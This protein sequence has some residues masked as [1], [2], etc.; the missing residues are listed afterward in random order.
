M[1][2]SMKVSS[3]L[4][5]VV[6]LSNTLGANVYAEGEDKPLVT[7]EVE[8]DQVIVTFKEDGQSKKT[9]LD[10]VSV[11][12]IET[13]EVATL[14]VP[15]GETVEAFIDE[16]EARTDVESVE[17]DHLVQLTYTPNDPYFSYSQYHH[18]N[19]ETERAWDKT[20]GSS[21]V[22]VAVLDSGFDI[23]HSD[24][25][26]QIVSPLA[27]SDTGFSVDDHGTHV[28]GII[29]SSIDNYAFGAG[30]APETSI[31]PIDVFEDDMAY[32]SD[33]IEGI[34]QAVWAGADII[35]MSMGSYS[36]N[37]QYNN[38]IQYAYQSGLVIVASAGNDS[39]S[40]TRYPASY[41]NVI[42][43]GSTDSSDSQSY[44]SNYGNDVDIVAPGS[45]IYST[46]PYNSGGWMS[47]T[48][49]A[50][51]VVAGVAA[52]LLASEPNLTNDQV[53]DRLLS[54]TKD[55]GEY[56]KDYIYGNGLVNAK[57]ALKIMDIPSPMVPKIYDYSTS[58]IGYLSFDLENGKVFIRDQSGNIIASEENYIGYTYFIIPISQQTAG[59]KLYVSI[60]DSYGN[61]SE[62]KE[63][64]VLD[65]TVPGKPTVHEVTDQSSVIKGAGEPGAFVS[66]YMNG[67]TAYSGSIDRNGNF[68]IP[69][70]PLKAGVELSVNVQD[71]AG[72][73]S[74]FTNVTVQDATAPA[75]PEVHE[76]TED[77]L[78]VTGTA[79]AGSTISVKAKD[80]LLGE[81]QADG[82]GNYSIAIAKQKAGTLLA[83]TATD[84]AG[85]V[86]EATDIKV[87]DNAAPAMPTVSEVTD[88]ST[89]VKGT[90]E[91]GSSI[92]VKAAAA[93][94][95][96]ATANSD[97]SFAVTIAKQKAGTKL[98]VTAADA[99]G[100]ISAAKQVTVVDATAPAAPTVDPVTDKST[101]VTGTGEV[102]ASIS[103]K[104]GDNELGSAKVAADGKFKVAISAQKAGTKI[105]VTA[106]DAAGNKST[107][108][109]V[110][111][112]DGTPPAT[113][114][115]NEVTDKS[116]TVTGMAEAEATVS[117]KAD[118]KQIGS[119]ISGAEGKFS[120]AIPKQKGD[121]ILTITATDEYGNSSEAVSKTVK[122]TT[123]PATPAV[124]KVTENSTAVTGTG[125]VNALIT[126][127]NGSKE[128]GTAKADSK[129]IYKI[130]IAKQK[131]GTTLSVTATDKAG[132]VSS[133]K[134]IVV[135]DGTPPEISLTNKVTHH[136]TRVIGTAEADAKITV[137]AGTKSIGTATAN[138]KGKYEVTIAKQKVGTRLS[139]VATDAAGNSSNAIAVTVVDGNYPDLK[140]THWALD[141]IMYLADDQIIGGYP[142]GGFQP[143][144]NTT[145]AEAAKMLA[146]AL[147][148]PIVETSSGYKDVSSKHW[149]KDYIA[150][151]SK[152][153]LFNGNPDGTFAPNAVLKRAEMAKV[154]SI[155]YGLN[156]S[157]K[158][159]FKDVKAGHWAK[160]YISGLYE[161]GITTGFP[162]KTFRPGASTTRAEYSVFLARALN[163]DFR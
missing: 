163:E 158:N 102:N 24:L 29:G 72:N 130:A 19:I 120:V 64:T 39:S 100:N 122:D 49:M 16:L 69:I 150:A 82:N 5:S 51:P 90:A 118:G 145:R 23:N 106:T 32:T 26:N 137:K 54:T 153:G 86:S 67:Y 85:N 13:E 109:E 128:L 47:G 119:A 111:V 125:E 157:N 43:V 63:I 89:V 40:Q 81:S 162:D 77:S 115:V 152:A 126:V 151:V 9:D 133:V 79:E 146:L 154:I 55:L 113:P 148:L 129:G 2:K 46:L 112:T 50:A 84:Q 93:E 135:V 97:G 143:E 73:T 131:V 6:L 75:K 4:L 144:K 14:K 110:S 127:K 61:E 124:D 42:S 96:K 141:E 30:V 132:N 45:S 71:A 134:E 15:E 65:G 52:L 138:A 41:D 121:T 123:A 139:V 36:Y 136:S 60:V 92:V 38:A 117:V 27:T 74:E 159:H 70:S 34:Y 78:K 99:S 57:Q 142:N 155:A 28:A 107:V 21:D 53:V 83:I 66:V 149:A 25:A 94:I 1:N 33:I 10:V 56:G 87:K 11:D 116:T 17:A 147:D 44:F 161:N 58:V 140:L 35:N 37:S 88:K 104:A 48:S 31:M 80:V 62:A 20:M 95:G 105:Q 76:V 8:T 108:K 7:Q 59:T 91:A 12:T 160:G 3:A 18:K 98:S 114:T 68:E 22:V 156:A 103:V 101:A